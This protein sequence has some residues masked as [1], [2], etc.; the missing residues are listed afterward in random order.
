MCRR[1]IV[2]L[3]IYIGNGSLGLKYCVSSIMAGSYACSPARFKYIYIPTF[4]KS[5]ARY[6]FVWWRHKLLFAAQQNYILVA[7]EANR[8]V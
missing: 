2:K 6:N 7:A 1:T 8:G 3:Y 4:S 5:G